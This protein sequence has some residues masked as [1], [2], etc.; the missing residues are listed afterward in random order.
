MERI[1]YSKLLQW[2]A[3]RDFRPLLLLGARQVGKTYLIRAFCG[4]EYDRV[5]EVNLFNYPNIVELYNSSLSADEKFEQFKLIVNTDMDSDGFKQG[6]ILFIDEIQESESLIS[7]LKFL[8]ETKPGLRVI[9]SGSLLGVRLKRLKKAFPVGQVEMLR[10]HPLSFDEFLQATDNTL[11]RDAISECF[12]FDRALSS[13]VHERALNLYRSFLCLGGMPEVINAYLQNGR[14]LAGVDRRIVRQI[15]EAYFN[16]MNK[17]V[18][19]HSESNRIEGTYRSIPT[20]MLNASRKF[21]YAKID[22]GARARGYSTA[23][24]WLIAADMVVPSTV[25]TSGEVPLNAHIDDG[26]FKMYLS[27]IGFLVSLVNLDF[28]DIMTNQRFSFKGALAENYVACE[29]AAKG[30]ELHYWRSENRAEVDFLLESGM[31]RGGVIPV[32]VKADKYVRTPSLT[33]YGGK[34][35][36]KYSI[37][38]S[39]KNFGFENQIKS[40][41]LYAAFCIE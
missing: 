21:Q 23:L 32:E 15:S 25:V 16:D 31:T 8:R 5:I 13:S 6:G 35:H 33:V 24:D 20:Q 17:Y 9:C 11:L 29:L 12:T 4:R 14:D 37:R 10:L 30:R 18:G 27:D 36:P 2:K 7:E 28:A 38:I 22:K 39:A 19:N 1:L 40:V 41:P 34:F 26:V 3:R